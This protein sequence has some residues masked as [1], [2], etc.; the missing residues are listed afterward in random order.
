MSGKSAQHPSGRCGA[1]PADHAQP[2]DQRGE[3]YERGK[4]RTDR[5]GGRKSGEVHAE[6]NRAGYRDR[7]DAGESWKGF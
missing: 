1:Y 3:I 5:T 7:H 2:A 4:G 6:D